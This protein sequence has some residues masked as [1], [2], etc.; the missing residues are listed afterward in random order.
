MTALS[1]TQPLPLRAKV[2]NYNMLPS[3]TTQCQAM[4]QAQFAPLD[5]AVRGPFKGGT[6]QSGSFNSKLQLFKR[7][8]QWPPEM[9]ASHPSRTGH[10]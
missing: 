8:L 6:S 5:A 3:A 10:A 7:E 1:T 9:I 2:C 4:T